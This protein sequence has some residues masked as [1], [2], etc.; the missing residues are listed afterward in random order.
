MCTCTTVI[1][2]FYIIWL[3]VVRILLHWDLNFKSYSVIPNYEERAA[4]S[5]QVLC[6]KKYNNTGTPDET[7]QPRGF[8]WLWPC[9]RTCTLWIVLVSVLAWLIPELALVGIT[10][11]D[12]ACVMRGPLIIENFNTPLQS[13]LTLLTLLIEIDRSDLAMM[14]SWVVLGE[15]IS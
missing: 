2:R 10:F 9:L 7:W 14:W 1:T 12:W 4:A 15:M 3:N 11:W 5:K 6:F 13:C 8:L